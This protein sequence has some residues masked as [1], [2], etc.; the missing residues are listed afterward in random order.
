M[1]GDTAAKAVGDIAGL[2]KSNAVPLPNGDR[3]F[4]LEVPV[5]ARRPAVIIVVAGG[6]SC[7]DALI[8]RRGS[9]LPNDARRSVETNFT[10][11]R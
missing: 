4:P 6:G 2:E 3:D 8:V 10:M 9:P 11:K 1:V 7:D 5:G